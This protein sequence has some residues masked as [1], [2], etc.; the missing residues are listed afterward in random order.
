MTLS[1]N[2]YVKDKV[3]KGFK[4]KN[5]RQFFFPYFQN[6]GPRASFQ[7]LVNFLKARIFSKLALNCGKFKQLVSLQ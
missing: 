3:I 4:K 1:K 7:L 2:I 5:Q 6:Q